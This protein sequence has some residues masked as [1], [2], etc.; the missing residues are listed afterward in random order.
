LKKKIQRFL[1]KNT[2]KTILHF[3]GLVTEIKKKLL[4]NNFEKKII[5]V[6]T[7]KIAV[8]GH[9]YSGI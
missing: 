6:F 8:K 7:L 2:T 3:Y 4:Q 5:A 9:V 1:W